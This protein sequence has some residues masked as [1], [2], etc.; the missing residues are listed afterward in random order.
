MHHIPTRTEVD[1]LR[2]HVYE[3]RRELRALQRATARLRA[4]DGKR[5]VRRR[6]PPNA[7]GANAKDEDPDALPS[8]ARPRAASSRSSPSSRGR[9]LRGGE[10]LRS[11]KDQD[12]QIATTPK[13][14]CSG[15]TRRCSIATTPV[16]APTVKT[17]VL[18]V[19][20]LVGRYTMADLQEDRSL[21]RNLLAQGV[22]LYAVDWGNPTRADRWLTIDD[23]V[24]G[25]LADCVESHLPRARRRPDQSARH[26]RRRR[27]H[28]RATPRCIPSACKNLIVT[29]TPIDFHADQAEGRPDH[30]FINLWTRSLDTGGR[31]PPD[32]GQRQPA[33]RAHE[34]RVL[35][36]DAARDAHQVQ[37][38]HARRRWTTR[39]SC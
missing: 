23:Y 4:V 8:A 32:R 34:L 37:P 20:G 11:V 12:V 30:G 18:V 13:R 16:A 6:L 39:R 31:R 15:R 26:L 22:D 33:R 21:I 35:D 3:L 38:R 36:D 5:D 17:P 1:E 2:A 25:Y 29:I 28:A 14:R 27:V 10:L 19:Y 24:D 9:L 7:R